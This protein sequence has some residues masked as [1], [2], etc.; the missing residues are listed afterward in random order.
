M[1]RR[2]VPTLMVLNAIRLMRTPYEEDRRPR[3]NSVEIL[4]AESGECEKVCYAALH[5]D[6]DRGLLDYGVSIRWPWL[7]P[8]GQEMLE[9]EWQ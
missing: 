1:A 4:M 8:K 9:E 6:S 7:T 2:H 3:R 5:R